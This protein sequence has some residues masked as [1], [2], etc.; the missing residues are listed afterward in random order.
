M[1]RRLHKSNSTIYDNH[2]KRLEIFQ[3]TGCLMI[4]KYYQVLYEMAESKGV[5]KP[6]KLKTKK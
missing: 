3:K 1:V 6:V 5:Y 2:V 4:E